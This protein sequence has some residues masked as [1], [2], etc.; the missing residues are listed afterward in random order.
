LQGKDIGEGIARERVRRLE[1]F[2][3]EQT[4]S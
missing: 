3:R 2:R 4:S 1:E